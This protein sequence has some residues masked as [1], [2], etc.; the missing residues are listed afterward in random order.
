MAGKK[1]II[2]VG[3]IIIFTLIFG[4]LFVNLK[5]GINASV[6]DDSNVREITIDAKRFEYN[7]D[8]IKIKWGE[9]VRLKINN[10]DGE[11]GFSIP[12]LGIEVHDEKG[13]V[14]VADEKGT[15]DFYCH[16]YCGSGHSGMKG[17]LVVE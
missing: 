7:P 8:V 11:H 15:F 6:I 13:T 3:I 4:L 12:E 17:V 2:I 16:H 14:F 9:I 10:I 1:I 5:A